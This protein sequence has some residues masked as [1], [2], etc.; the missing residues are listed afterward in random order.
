MNDQPVSGES[1]SAQNHKGSHGSLYARLR[2][3]GAIDGVMALLEEARPL[4]AIVELAA[5]YGV[6]AS[7]SSA[8]SLKRAHLHRWQAEKIRTAA[9]AEGI[10][11]RHLPAVV[12]EQLERLE[13]ATRDLLFEVQTS[14]QLLEADTGKRSRPI[15]NT[16]PGK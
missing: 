13:T 9:A 5:T 10:H 14:L 12:R 16:P 3:V 11:E 1:D 6:H 4:R 8:H 7:I 2:A 15:K